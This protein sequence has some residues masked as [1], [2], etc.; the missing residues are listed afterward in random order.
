MPQTR[1]SDAPP[2][3]GG[4]AI[5]GLK[6]GVLQGCTSGFAVTNSS[7]HAVEMTTAGHCFDQGASVTNYKLVS[8]S[9]QG[10]GYSFGTNSYIS[11]DFD[12]SLMSGSTY[13]GHIYDSDTTNLAVGGASDPSVGA[14]Y[15]VSGVY[16]G[17]TCG[18]T[19]VALETWICSYTC[20]Y[21]NDYTGGTITK[22]GDS[23]APWYLPAGVKAY[24]RGTH[25]GI[26]SGC[27]TT[28]HMYATPWSGIANTYPYYTIVTG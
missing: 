4:A 9:W 18:H 20:F 22:S 16:G 19:L 28:C 13:N 7:T 26:S 14:S 1:V 2:H 8:G 12:F 24:I 15:C 25:Y 21:A 17:K 3:W 10:A 6:G 5:R 27:T 11:L 23:G